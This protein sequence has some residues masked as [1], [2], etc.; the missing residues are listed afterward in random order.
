MR[1]RSLLRWLTAAWPLRAWAQAPPLPADTLR[2]LA[3][4]VLP[5]ELGAEGIARTAAAFE[6]WLRDYHAG[7]EMDHGY[8][9]TRLRFKPPSPAATYARQ[10]ESL[11]A[12]LL[13]GDASAARAAV[14]TALEEAKVANL[15]QSPDGRHIAGDLMAFYFRSG[16]ANDLCYRAHIGRYECRGLPGSEK[17]PH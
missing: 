2:A 6:A 7:A 14:G 8:G 11:R 12:V 16:E 9:F 4:V 17:E 13:A 5:S 3:G 1:R 15:P 10:L